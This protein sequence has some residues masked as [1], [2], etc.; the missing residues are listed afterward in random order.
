MDEQT[1]V[2][3]KDAAGLPLSWRIAIVVAFVLIVG[4][5]V[6]QFSS[7]STRTGFESKVATAD[8]TDTTSAEAQFQ[9]GNDYYKS[10]QYE[11]AIAAYKKVIELDPTYQAA[12]ANLGVVYYQQQQFD[13]AISQYEKALELKS[14]DTEVAYN[15]AVLYLR[16]GLQQTPPDPGLLEQAVT[17]LKQIQ[18]T[19]PNLAEVYFS[20]GVAYVSL[21][22]KAEARQAFERFLSFDSAQDPQAIQE[23]ERYLPQANQKE[24]N[25]R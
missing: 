11:Q 17:Q 24:V 21:N 2:N 7:T 10:G 12:Y 16:Q 4:I 13:L 20:L 9:A 3:Q 1:V 5:F 14:D 8:Q 23:A 19:T 6:Y 18:E 25:Y 22:Q 15:L